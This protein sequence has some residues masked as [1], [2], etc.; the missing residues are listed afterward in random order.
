MFVE[1]QAY[2]PRSLGG[3]VDAIAEARTGTRAKRAWIMPNGAVEIAFFL[4]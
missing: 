2:V 4:D 3:V 1:F